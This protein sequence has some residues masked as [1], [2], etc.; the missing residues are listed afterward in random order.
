[1]RPAYEPKDATGNVIYDQPYPLYNFSVSFY[2][3]LKADQQSY[4]VSFDT[5]TAVSN[6]T[7]DNSITAYQSGKILTVMTDISTLEPLKVRIFNTS[8]MLIN[9]FSLMS[10]S[11]K[12]K[13]NYSLANLQSG[14]YL[15]NIES[16]TSSKT[17]KLILN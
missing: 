4:N 1:M 17:V 10:G 11:G 2:Y 16:S 6:P 8:G 9:S 5:Q 7:S 3:T 12:N 15:A 13:R 14:V